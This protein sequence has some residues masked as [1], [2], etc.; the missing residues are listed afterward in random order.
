MLPDTLTR[1]QEWFEKALPNP[2]ERQFY[3][4]MGVHFEEVVEMID[5]LS[6]INRA[7]TDLLVGARYALTQLANHLKNVESSNIILHSGDRLE[8]IDSLCDQI[9]TATGTGYLANMNIP[10]GLKEVNRSNFSKFDD[11][12]NP[13]FKDNGKIGKSPNYTEPDLTPYI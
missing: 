10:G 2:P 11:D 1:T 3:V 7:G 8:F 12:G 13:V 6:S 4:Q 5:S 9:V